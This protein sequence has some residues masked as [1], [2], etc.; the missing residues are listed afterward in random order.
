MKI[1][2]SLIPTEGSPAQ[3]ASYEY[4]DTG[5]KN[6]QTY[7]YKLEDIDLSGKTTL[8]SPVSAM[9]KFVSRKVSQY[10]MEQGISKKT[11]VIN[12]SP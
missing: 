2:D 1:N 11:E 3:G 7:Y 4:V 6:R 9:P 8:H 10:R 12:P 5:V